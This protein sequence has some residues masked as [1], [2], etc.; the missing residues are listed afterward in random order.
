MKG[1]GDEGTGGESER[2]MV[3]VGGLEPQTDVSLRNGNN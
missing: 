2:R 3:P 1:G